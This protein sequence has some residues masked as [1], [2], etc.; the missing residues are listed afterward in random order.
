MGRIIVKAD[1]NLDLYV[2]WST[3]ADGPTCVGSRKEMF[4]HL[5]KGD[6]HGVPTA[7]EVEKRLTV[8]DLKG[9]SMID[10]PEGYWEDEGFIPQ[11]HQ[12]QRWLRRSRFGAYC[13]L[14]ASGDDEG[15]Y[16]L[17]EPLDSEVSQ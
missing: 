17:T 2:E 14:A 6:R 16:L 5:S 7:A 12:G 4:H 13:L 8:A 10:M 9:S 15:A 11:T 3:I 1:K